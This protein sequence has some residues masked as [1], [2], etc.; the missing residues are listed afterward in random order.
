MSNL[1]YTPGRWGLVKTRYPDE[2]W[3]GDY[4]VLGQECGGTVAIVTRTYFGNEADSNAH[5]IKSAPMLY[6]ALCD[7]V[8]DRDCLS[9]ATIR[10]AKEA[11]AEAR[12]ETS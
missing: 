7:M 9:G 6:E 3:D 11:I 2:S 8:S 12:G 5:L 1:N 10:F 4:E